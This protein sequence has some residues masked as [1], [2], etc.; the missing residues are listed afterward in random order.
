MLGEVVSSDV[1]FLPFTDA[2]TRLRGY[3]AI[4]FASASIVSTLIALIWFC[5]LRKREFRR[6]LIVMLL[7]S[8]LIKAI[9]YLVYPSVV[10][11]RGTIN[12]ERALCT[13]T[14]FFINLGNEAGGALTIPLRVTFICIHHASELCGSFQL[15]LVRCTTS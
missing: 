11:T 6:T 15:S 9:S 12:G 13:A 4:G 2:Q 3:L 5:S 7:V 10:I 14:G 1:T 8:N